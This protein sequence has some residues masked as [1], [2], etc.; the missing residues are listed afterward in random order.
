M[1]PIGCAVDAATTATNA[2]PYALEVCDG[3]PLFISGGIFA[4]DDY[5]QMFAVSA[6][7][8]SPI[9][10][11]TEL[12]KVQPG[13]WIKSVPLGF[14]APVKV[15]RVDS[16]TV[17]DSSTGA[18]M[19]RDKI[20]VSANSTATN[21]CAAIMVTRGLIAPLTVRQS[22]R[23][24]ELSILGNHTSA[25]QLHPKMKKGDAYDVG[26][27]TVTAFFGTLVAGNLVVRGVELLRSNVMLKPSHMGVI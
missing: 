24:W 26:T 14:S 7:A 9:L 25:L 12:G 5:Y 4:R 18:R 6:T 8:G 15:M 13:D 19:Q 20:T 22:G 11:S 1:V 10:Y 27:L 23:C 21:S 16:E 2:P 17:Q 3:A